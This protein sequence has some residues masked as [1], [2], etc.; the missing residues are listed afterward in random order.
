[1][2]LNCRLWQI[3]IAHRNGLCSKIPKMHWC[4]YYAHV[5]T[6]TS[7]WQRTHDHKS[8]LPKV[9][10]HWWWHVYVCQMW[11]LFVFE[12]SQNALVFNATLVEAMI[13]ILLLKDCLV[14]QS[15][16][17]ELQLFKNLWW[18]FLGRR[19]DKPTWRSRSG[20]V[21]FGVFCWSWL[22]SDSSN[23]SPWRTQNTKIQVPI[24]PSSK[25]SCIMVE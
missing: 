6:R 17:S 9:L 10:K 1:M 19:W 16:S 20:D 13:W 18:H 24:I 14:I 11:Q 22:L 2:F 23:N 12:D 21:S 8:V 25:F 3:S 7:C 15:P 5:I 4:L